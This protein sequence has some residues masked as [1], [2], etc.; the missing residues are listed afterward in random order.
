MKVRVTTCNT[1]LYICFLFAAASRA[2]TAQTA[3][4]FP[5]VSTPLESAWVMSADSTGVYSAGEIRQTPDSPDGAR[6]YLR[7]FDAYGTEL[8]THQF[9][10]QSAVTGIA[11][12]RSGVF[13]AGNAS[14]DSNSNGGRELFLKKY[15]A[16]GNELW[17]W[18]SGRPIEVIAASGAVAAD[19][20]GVYLLEPNLEH[21][22]T[23][24]LRRFDDG[25]RQLWSLVVS[26]A[27][28]LSADA[29]GIYL[30]DRAPAYQMANLRKFNRAGVQMW[31]RTLRNDALGYFAA[32]SD[33]I[34]M[35]TVLYSSS[36]QS[37]HRYF[38]AYDA[39][40]DLKWTR[41]YPIEFQEPPGG[42]IVASDDGFYFATSA[43]GALDGQCRAGYLDFLVSRFDSQGNRLW[44]RQLG[45]DQDDFPRAI[46]VGAAGVYIAGGPYG[47][48]SV[49]VRLDKEPDAPSS[50][51]RIHHECVL[52]AANYVGG[53]IAPGEMVTI[54]GSS[55][56]PPEGIQAHA[57]QDSPLPATLGNTRVLFNGIPGALLYASDRQ[58]TVIVPYALAG[59]K[60][61]E[62][63]VEYW[64]ERSNAVLLP[65]KETRL[66]LF[67]LDGSGRGPA[68][69]WNEDGTLNSPDNPALSGSVVT[70][71]ATGAP[72]EN[73]SSEATVVSSPAPV[74]GEVQVA[75]S[76]PYPESGWNWDDVRI[77]R[78]A[79][80]SAGGVTGAVSGLIQI[81]LRLPGV[82]WDFGSGIWYPQLMTLSDSI[83]SSLATIAVKSQ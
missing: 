9:D 67:S 56:G 12:S 59:Q 65:L 2:L 72:L 1:F 83:A 14:I 60:S 47:P 29:T 38:Q 50:V 69:A 43:N 58:T 82:G 21:A 11:T 73:Q 22:S 32:N 75:F 80:L 8:W 31:A 57:S 63:R 36:D 76:G 61:V 70:L 46:A 19:D 48:F 16:D 68:A 41:E 51:P 45:S 54:L 52:N 71:Y 4:F 62:V 13:V 3:T 7:K 39:N 49:I 55:L 42:V 26:Y 81:R 40:G 74:K 34:Y 25:G 15:D 66:G 18:R 10:G 6:A 30:I 37:L 27:W 77:V 35:T 78:Y 23:Q 20:A 44:R 64:G 24:V 79:S 28:A 53:G 33:G 17:T 5:R